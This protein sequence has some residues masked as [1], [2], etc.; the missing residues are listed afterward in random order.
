MR[1]AWAGGVAA[2]VAVAGAAACHHDDGGGTTT[3]KPVTAGPAW[4]GNDLS[5]LPVGDAVVA[6]VNWQRIHG[7]EIYGSVF[8]PMIEKIPQLAMVR[9]TCGFD[10]LATVTSMTVGVAALENSEDAEIVVH[11]LPK[12]K[13]IAC[14]PQ[15]VAKAPVDAHV[16][17]RQDGDTWLVGTDKAQM[18]VRFIAPDVALIV[19]GKNASQAGTDA[20][21][22]G[23]ATSVTTS[24]GFNELH[25]KVNA[26]GAVWFIVNATAKPIPEVPGLQLASGGV[27]VTD[28]V[29]FDMRMRFDTEA[30][31]QQFATTAKAQGAGMAAM[32]FDKFD[33]GADGKEVVF[34]LGMSHAKLASVLQMT[35]MGGGGGPSPTP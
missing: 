4:D 25:G 33:I 26:Q 32:M 16:K 8:A 27:D 9:S 19:M 21:L 1:A 31:A 5:L 3:P 20:L 30:N 14:M 29:A 7:S 24:A 18:G 2:V 13:V 22:A 23:A 17:P 34:G 11:G 28:A 6:G 12:D 35:G 15:I 10:P